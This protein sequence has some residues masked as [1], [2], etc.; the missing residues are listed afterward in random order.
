[1]KRHTRGPGGYINY[2][3]GNNGRIDV[4]AF[5]I[6]WVGAV[7][8]NFDANQSTL[9][10]RRVGGLA[11]LGQIRDGLYGTAARCWRGILR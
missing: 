9:N 1:M 2:T 11:P 4:Y 6:G 3:G 10:L 5:K 7:D 8:Y